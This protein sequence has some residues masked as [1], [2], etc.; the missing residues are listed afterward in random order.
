MVTSA[1]FFYWLWTSLIQFK[2]SG[3]RAWVLDTGI[4]GLNPAQGVDFC[5][6]LY[7]LGRGLATG[8]SA[9]KESCQMSKLIH[10]FRSNSELDRLQGQIRKS[11]WYCHH[12]SLVLSEY[13]VSEINSTSASIW[14]V[15]I[16]LVDVLAH[17]QIKDAKMRLCTSQCLFIT[18]VCIS[19]KTSWILGH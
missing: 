15:A 5:P 17:S 1:W 19:G 14:L 3:S 11:W 13:D 2:V 18:I 10:N 4:A 6:L 9:S 12:L 8:W 16:T 7:V